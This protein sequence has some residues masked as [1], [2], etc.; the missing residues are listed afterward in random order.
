MTST[1]FAR[2]VLW[3]RQSGGKLQGQ[4]HLVM[5]RIYK[6]SNL[7]SISKYDLKPTSRLNYLGVT[8]DSALKQLT[9]PDEKLDKPEPIF[10]QALSSGVIPFQTVE[11]LVGGCT[12][13]RQLTQRQHCCIIHVTRVQAYRT[14]SVPRRTSASHGYRHSG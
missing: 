6:V 3:S 8:Y 10:E 1:T 4:R 9:I 5:N 12:I 13:C 7:M 14:F 11:R 2:R